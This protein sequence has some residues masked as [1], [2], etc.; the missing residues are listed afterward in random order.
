[1]VVQLKASIFEAIDKKDKKGQTL[2]HGIKSTISAIAVHPFKPILAIAGA[3]GFLMLWD[4]TKKDSFVGQNFEDWTK[5]S[6]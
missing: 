6:R 1:M 4:Y 5:D 3:E 2:M